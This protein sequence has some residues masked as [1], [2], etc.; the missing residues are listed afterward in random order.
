[1]TVP[2]LDNR[3]ATVPSV[4]KCPRSLRRCLVGKM[5]QPRHRDTSQRY[6]RASLDLLSSSH[7]WNRLKVSRC[8]DE[9]LT[10]RSKGV[11][12]RISTADESVDR[13]PPSCVVPRNSE[14]LFFGKRRT[15]TRQR[16]GAAY[17][18]AT[19]GTKCAGKVCAGSAPRNS[20][21]GGLMGS[22]SR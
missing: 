22:L 10:N 3:G 5:E 20:G 16:N 8:P 9:S 17:F 6:T 2:S 1:M 11:G 21:R 7:A 4:L 13:C 14:Y 19:S 12:G 18:C 15:E